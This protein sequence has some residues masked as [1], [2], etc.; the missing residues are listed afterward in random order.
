MN[1]FHRY[2]R[3][4]HQEQGF[5]L[6]IVMGMGSVM[7]LVAAALISR[8]QNSQMIATV[9][10]RSDEATNAAEIGV[11]RLQSYLS[12]QR[13]FATQNSTNWSALAAGVKANIGSCPALTQNW[14]AG[15]RY[16]D[17]QWLETGTA[18]HQYRLL[19]YAY[20]PQ[21][22]SHGQVGM[23]TL[24]V[25]G[26][27]TSGLTPAISR[28]AVEIPIAIA[29]A[30]PAPPALWVKSLN[31]SNQAQITGN[32]LTTSCPDLTDI[33]RVSG[34]ANINI[35]TDIHNQPTGNITAAAQPLWPQP[36]RAPSSAISVPVIR[37]NITLPRATDL[38]DAQGHFDYVV[39]TDT[40]NN[41]IQLPDGKK[42][43]VKVA[44]NQVVNLYTRGDI[45]LGGG[46]VTVKM[47][48][49]TQ[50]HPEK[51]RIYGSD[52]TLKFSIKDS[53]SVMAS[54][55]APL[56]IGTAAAASKTGTGITGNLWLQQWDT[57]TNHSRL[58]IKQLGTWQDLS[59]PA[60]EQLGLQLQPISSWQR[61]GQE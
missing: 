56:A 60:E 47:V 7:V 13:L 58:P 46:Q 57:A 12:Q 2:Q 4:A 52:R 10:S 39:D 5:T 29:T 27:V 3:S 38:P 48:G 61:R 40:L 1:N 22:S 19:S 15:Q 23:A 35:A 53:A 16:A 50:P 49:N 32:V 43:T 18:N 30:Q 28:L 44:A 21:P 6:P 55:Q 24:T 14:A 34:I 37:D 42:I 20:Q 45:D 36:R 59:I 33:D 31:M 9:Q 8:A 51:L 54:I 25:E 41:S 17:Q 26:R 11:T